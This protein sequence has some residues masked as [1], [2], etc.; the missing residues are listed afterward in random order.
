MALK[1]KPWG[2]SAIS[3]KKSNFLF[4]PTVLKSAESL[5][6]DCVKRVV[7]LGMADEAD[8]MHEMFVEVEWQ[9]R[10]FGVPLAQIEA[11][12]ADDDSVEAIDDWKYW[13]NG[14]QLV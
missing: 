7:V 6:S 1:N 8:C 10:H 9:G 3:T 13:I 5:H 12:D 14:Y 11:L 2:G 4:A